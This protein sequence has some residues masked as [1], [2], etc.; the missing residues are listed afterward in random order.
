M[1]SIEKINSNYPESKVGIILQKKENQKL[2]QYITKDAFGA[3]LFPGNLKGYGN[4]KFVEDMSEDI[5]KGNPIHLWLNLPFCKYKCNYCQFPVYIMKGTSLAG[6]IEIDEWINLIKE[7]I[8]LW[9]KAIPAL[10]DVPIGEVNLFG[11]TPTQLQ[12]EYIRRLVVYLYEEFN[13]TEE[14]TMRIEGSPDSL[15]YN[16]LHFLRELGFQKLSFG[17]QTFDE[18]VL[19]LAGRLHTSEQVIDVVKNAHE[20]GFI[21][22]SGD[23][24]YGLPGQTVTGFLE[25]VK[26]MIDLMFDTIVIT[27]LH[28]RNFGETRTAISGE[29][30]AAWEKE[31]VR[32]K[33]SNQGY[34]WPELGEIYQMREQAVKILR[35]SGYFESP[36]MYFNRRN[37][38]VQK[39][40]ALVVNQDKQFPELGIGLGASS[41]N[42]KS[43]CNNCISKEEY[44]SQIRQGVLPISIING[45]SS[46]ERKKR[47][48]RMALTSCKPVYDSIFQQKFRESLLDNEKYPFFERL[49]KRG[50][51]LVDKTDGV[52]QLTPEGQTLVEAIINC[53]I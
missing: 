44:I 5:K 22:V 35:K 32:A 38:E 4:Q 20:L 24:I 15:S 1:N 12:D 11:G 27:K 25:D 36:T 2:L 46:E 52:I 9:K 33:I 28:L 10:G 26:R 41:C 43:E 49:E 7:E 31:K 19:K 45:F 29:K 34:H 51:L 8:R 16:K 17:I 40:K 3:H 53:E 42:Y 21:D 39:W 13:I 48:I 30:P 14:T 18:E 37:S 23:L 50:L 6:F 47:S